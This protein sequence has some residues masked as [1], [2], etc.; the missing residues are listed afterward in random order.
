MIEAT[1]KLKFKFI[2]HL[3]VQVERNFHRPV[4]NGMALQESDDISNA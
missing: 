4:K 1:Q 3:S 2:K